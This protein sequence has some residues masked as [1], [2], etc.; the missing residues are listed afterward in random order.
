M[1]QKVLLRFILPL[2]VF[3]LA[4]YVAFWFIKSG[5]I[6]KNIVSIIDKNPNIEAKSITS[7]GFP[8]K[9]NIEIIG[10]RIKSS[11]SFFSGGDIF[12]SSVSAKTG[13]FSNQFQVAVG[14]IKV[15]SFD[16]KPKNVKFNKDPIIN[17]TI[18]DQTISKISYGDDGYS[19]LNSE[20]DVIFTVGDS[21]TQINLDVSDNSQTITIDSNF[22]NIDKFDIFNKFDG[23]LFGDDKNKHQ[24]SE[25]SLEAMDLGDKDLKGNVAIE[26]KESFKDKDEVV[27]KDSVNQVDPENLAASENG[28]LP[29]SLPSLAIEE[30]KKKAKKRILKFAPIEIYMSA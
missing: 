18:K 19:I 20:G 24:K 22:R 11:N 25:K 28:V 27:R 3:L 16:G 12:I 6:K 15:E 23:N 30:K 1:V 29:D 8:F 9:N 2:L 14:N 17:I 13:I 21:D 7:S 26:N 10:L 5:E 4:S